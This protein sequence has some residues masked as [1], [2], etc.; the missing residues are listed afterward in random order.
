MPSSTELIKELREKTGAGI[1]ECKKAIEDAIGDLE[2]CRGCQRVARPYS[3]PRDDP[4][5]RYALVPDPCRFRVEAGRRRAETD[6]NSQVRKVLR[7]PRRD[8]LSER[9]A[10]E[11]V[12]PLEN[13]HGRADGRQ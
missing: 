7:S 6:V 4:G 1:M 9:P 2:T 10:P 5:G 11:P 8:R 12:R 3:D 13:G